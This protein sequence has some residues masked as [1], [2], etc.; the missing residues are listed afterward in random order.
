VVKATRYCALLICLTALPL[1][2]GG[3][4]ILRL[5]VGQDYARHSVVFLEI[6]IVGNAIRLLGYP[7]A[8]VVVATAKQHLAT[9]SGVIEAAVNVA[10][11][12]YLV[13]R[14]GAAGVAI[15]TFVGAFVGLGVHLALSMV[16]TRATILLSR[17]TFVLQGLLRP[18]SCIV[19]SVLMLPL[20]RRL[21]T[22]PASPTIIA[23]W[24][25]ATVGIVWL[26]GL[27]GTE[28]LQFKNTL[29][30]KARWKQVSA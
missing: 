25:F 21:N 11:S 26:V 27:T 8:L 29:L 14:I 4:P 7:Y 30:R 1:L 16:R 3:Y 13:R 10:V 17:L 28:R 9:L 19:P 2:L 20:W 24:L 5:W 18:L 6:L 15:G 22:I 23:I 12:V